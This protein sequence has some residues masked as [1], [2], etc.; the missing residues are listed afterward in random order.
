ML[1]ISKLQELIHLKC[2]ALLKLE[3]KADS[4]H[5][6]LSWES[7]DSVNWLWVISVQMM[8]YGDQNSTL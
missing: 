5:T 6:W 4:K 3:L 2:I 7:Q 8:H 1:G